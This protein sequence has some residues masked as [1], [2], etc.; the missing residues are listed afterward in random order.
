VNPS[1]FV[2]DQFTLSEVRHAVEESVFAYSGCSFFREQEMENSYLTNSSLKFFDGDAG[3]FWQAFQSGLFHFMETLDFDRTEL[4]YG[5]ILKKLAG[6][7]AFIASYYSELGY[8]DEAMNMRFTYSGVENFHLGGIIETGKRKKEPGFIC[9][10]PVIDVKKQCSAVNVYSSVPEFA[11][12]LVVEVCERFN[13]PS[14]RHR[15]LADTVRK[16]LENRTI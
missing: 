1:S 16:F 4:E 12:D 8:E 11:A 15:D 2:R 7:A 10:I 14:S 9:R 6:A 13:V 5:E 3:Q